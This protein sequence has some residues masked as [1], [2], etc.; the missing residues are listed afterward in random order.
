MNIS[1]QGE[2]TEV[3]NRESIQ[4]KLKNKWHWHTIRE[5]DQR[6]KITSL[7]IDPRISGKVDMIKIPLQIIEENV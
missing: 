5:S 2:A 4:E 6:G 1:G 7:E 3:M